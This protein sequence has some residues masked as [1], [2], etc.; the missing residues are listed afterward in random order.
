MD[1]AEVRNIRDN[2]EPNGR[3]ARITGGDVIRFS[4]FV[5]LGMLLVVYPVFFLCVIAV[6][7]ALGLGA[8][9][10]MHLRRAGLELWHVLVLIALTG[11]ML[12]NYGFENLSI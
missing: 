7:A 12:L 6:A 4:L 11:Y 3:R 8:L 2:F 9:A 10:L 5:L 1:I